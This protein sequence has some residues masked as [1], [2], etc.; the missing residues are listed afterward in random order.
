MEKT[1]KDRVTPESRGQDPFLRAQEAW[2]EVYGRAVSGKRNWRAMCFVM[3]ILL[4]AAIAGIIWQ[5]AQSKVVPYVVVLDKEGQELH[6][7]K[8]TKSA[9]V[10]DKIFKKELGSF[11]KKARLTSVDRQLM[12]QNIGWLYAHILP[13]TLAYK[14]L[15][16]YYQK[17]NPFELVKKKTRIVNRINSILPVTDNTWSVEWQ[18][19]VRNVSDGEIDKIV[20]YNAILTVSKKNPETQAQWDHNPFGIWIVDIEWEKKS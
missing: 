15:N 1:L 12:K 16:N 5:G 20:N 11:I 7:G 2:N 3:A 17:N 13:N 8:A 9:T 14:K 18:E 6:T 19:T 4:L 10:D